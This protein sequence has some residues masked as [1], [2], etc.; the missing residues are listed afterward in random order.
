M[1]TSLILL[2][3]SPIKYQSDI[4]TYLSISNHTP[5]KLCI[6]LIALVNAILVQIMFADR[7]VIMTVHCDKYTN[8]IMIQR[9]ITVAATPSSLSLYCKQL[10]RN[11]AQHQ[12]EICYLYDCPQSGH[13][14]VSI[15][16]QFFVV[17]HCQD[18]FTIN[19]Q[20]ENRLAEKVQHAT[21]TVTLAGGVNFVIIYC[22]KSFVYT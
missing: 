14:S 11:M 15:I 18:N 5:I 8:V 4:S 7:R 10:S 3:V 13:S 16:N 22:N 19:G 12:Q 17:A 9:L 20:I 1:A 2:A 21:V 6:R